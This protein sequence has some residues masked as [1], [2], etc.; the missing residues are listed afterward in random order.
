[1]IAAIWRWFLA[2]FGRGPAPTI[3]HG[4]YVFCGWA[5]PRMEFGIV[6]GVQCPT[7]TPWIGM[8]DRVPL[9]GQYDERDPEITTK[10]LEWM[11]QGKID[12]AVYQVEWRHDTHE[13][14]WSH[15]ADNHLAVFS[16]VRFCISFFDVLNSTTDRT[17]YNDL[18]PAQLDASW[19]AFAFAMLR[20]TSV[21]CALRIDGRPVLF[22]GYAHNTSSRFIDIL[23]DEIP[24]AYLVAT[25]VEPNAMMQLKVKGFDAFT[26]Y[27]LYSVEGWAGILAA[28]RDRWSHSIEICK[29]TGIEYWVPATCGY[30]A[31]AQGIESPVFMPTPAEFT[32]HLRDARRFARDNAKY[33]R[34]QVISYAFTE[35]RE[36]GILEPME[37]GMIRSG[38]EMLRA[39]AAGAREGVRVAP[40]VACQRCLQVGVGDSSSSFR[41][42]TVRTHLAA[43]EELVA[44]APRTEL[45]GLADMV[46]IERILAV[47]G[48]NVCEQ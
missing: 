20:Y 40:G 15:C 43:Q 12:Y 37:P 1:M 14:L 24:N 36:G 8:P 35:F 27:L 2:L 16:P 25:A 48:Y 5:N 46:M 32:S 4:V 33:T 44:I 23:R 29:Q 19:R 38:D 18:T 6:P 30:D 39:H 28:Y 31:R 17:Y 41:P 13:L 45:F 21:P 22:L 10:R 9:L 3:T 47:F 11:Q 42:P 34:G 26:E 7:P